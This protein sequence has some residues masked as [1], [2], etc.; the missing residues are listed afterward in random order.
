MESTMGNVEKRDAISVL[1]AVK[2]LGV[3]R[4]TLERYISI[5]GIQKRFFLLDTKAY[6]S[7]ADFERLQQFVEERK[8]ENEAEY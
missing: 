5:L 8:A 1:R 4:K 2:Q 6:I 7:N 3:T